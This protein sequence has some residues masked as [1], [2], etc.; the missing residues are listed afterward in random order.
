M[1]RALAK[2]PDQRFQTARD[3]KASLLWAMEHPADSAPAKP[4]RIP[5]IAV[6]ATTM[7][8]GVAGVWLG[9]RVGQPSAASP[10]RLSLN[11]PPNAI[12][13]GSLTGI[14]PTPQLALSPDGRSIVF[15][16]GAGGSVILW[17][18]PLD[19]LTAHPLPGTEN[20]AD[21]FWSPDGR[22]I[23]FFSEGQLKKIPSGGGPVQ[24]LA[25]VA[26]SRGASWGRD[27]TILFSSGKYGLYR[28]ASSGGAVTDATKLDASRQEGSHRWPQLLPDGLHF[29]YLIRSSLPEYRGIY[30]GSLDGKTK[31]RLL[32]ADS[33][34]A[35]T[36]AGYLLYA[37]GDALLAQPFDAERLELTGQ[38]FGV[39]ERIGRAS[40]AYA[41]FSACAAG[42]LAYVGPSVHIGRL[43]WFDRDGKEAGSLGPEGDYIDFRLSPDE[44]QLGRH[45]RR[46]QARHGGYLADRHHPRQYVALHLWSLRSLP[47]GLVSGLQVADLPE[48]A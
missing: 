11:P 24:S 26:N 13:S 34:V 48:C 15:N 45:T 38:P 19:S 37:E 14:V 9:S 43:T 44:L 21:P 29:V 28:V 22:W 8:A 27:D 39:G 3:L 30:V 32:A 33:S 10:V 42:T 20:G 5:W 12:F 40:H 7:L 2:D 35:Y 1:K 23:G 47:A 46:L 6:A 17:V 4:T 36:P 31:K 25:T 16:A 18:R 41:S